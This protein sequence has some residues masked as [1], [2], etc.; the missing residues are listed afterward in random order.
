MISLSE[1]GEARSVTA[2]VP[3]MASATARYLEGYGCV[4]DTWED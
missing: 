1:G 3:L 2:S 4:L